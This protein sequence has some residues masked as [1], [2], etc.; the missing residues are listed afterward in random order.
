MP[1]NNKRSL[2]DLKP[3]L[4]ININSKISNYFDKKIQPRIIKV[5]TILK[6]I[7]IAL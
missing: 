2:P 4:N 5:N 6:I 7:I 1:Q 3:D